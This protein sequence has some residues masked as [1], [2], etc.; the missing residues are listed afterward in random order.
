MTKYLEGSFSVGGHG[1]EY[2]E[3]YERT[4]GERKPTRGRFVYRPNPETGQ[5]EAVQV[6][7]DWEGAERRAPVPT[8]E[9]VYGNAC[10]TDGTPI[11]TRKR[12]R[13]YLKATGLAM[14]QDFTETTAREKAK[15]EAIAQG[16]L[17]DKQRRE[18]VGRA[19]YQHKTRTRR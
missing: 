19:L 13:E 4:F 2:A 16:R 15:R 5:V 8:E 6:D 1:E 17:P 18:A 3:G 12:H 10:A 11:N 7:A 9:F 14:A